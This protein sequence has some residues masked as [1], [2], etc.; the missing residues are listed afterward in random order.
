[1]E[2]GPFQ[3]YEDSLSATLAAIMSASLIY[4]YQESEGESTF[5]EHKE[6]M[7][8]EFADYMNRHSTVGES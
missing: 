3:Q 5:E 2:V 8:L 6:N 1:M 4:S 7:L